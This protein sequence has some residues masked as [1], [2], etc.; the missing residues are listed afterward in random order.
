MQEVTISKIKLK[1]K[2]INKIQKLRP[3]TRCLSSK[4]L[5]GGK[6]GELI[7]PELV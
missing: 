3:T 6:P 7:F 1:L 2:A 4:V 5:G